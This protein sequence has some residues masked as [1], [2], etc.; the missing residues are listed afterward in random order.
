MIAA[1]LWALAGLL[2]WLHMLAGIPG[3]YL[4]QGYPLY[5]GLT[6]SLSALFVEAGLNTAPVFAFALLGR[7]LRLLGV[8]LVALIWTLALD[9]TIMPFTIDFGTTWQPF[10]ALREQAFHPL[11][12]PLA[13]AALLAASLWAFTRPRRPAAPAG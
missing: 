4:G 8:P 1:G 12:T 13:L 11:H 9:R 5:P 2:V 7:G 6:V 10:G 3:A